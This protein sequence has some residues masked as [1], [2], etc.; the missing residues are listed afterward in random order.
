LI[1]VRD[2]YINEPDGTKFCI[3]GPGHEA[4]IHNSLADAIAGAEASRH[5]Y[6][7]AA[8]LSFPLGIPDHLGHTLVLGTP[9]ADPEDTAVFGPQAVVNIGVRIRRHDLLGLYR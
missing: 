3:S 8:R 2:P 6:T 1:A 5:R 7:F 4:S 9:Y